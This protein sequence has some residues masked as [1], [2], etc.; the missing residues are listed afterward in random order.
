MSTF[1]T[2]SQSLSANG[3][4]AAVPIGNSPLKSLQIFGT[5]SATWTLEI[6]NNNQNWFP[7]SIAGTGA[8]LENIDHDAGWARVVLS[9][10][11]SGA[12][13]AAFCQLS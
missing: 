11:V 4:G 5:F 2:T 12:V 6:S 1:T 13:G 9:N 3:A 10:Y 7:T 8:A